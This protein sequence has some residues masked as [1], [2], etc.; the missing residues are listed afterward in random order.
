MSPH[1]EQAL[2]DLTILL[3]SQYDDLGQIV[4]AVQSDPNYGVDSITDQMKKIRQTE[5]RLGPLRTLYR[6]E[7]EYAEGKLKAVTDETIETVKTIMPKLA[8]LEKASVESL[9]RL[10]P[11]IQGSVRA[12][13]MQSAYRGNQHA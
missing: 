2:I 11:K 5:D 6:Q 3:K 9:R 8:G 13:Q 4:D 7:K 12:A 1:E 10:F